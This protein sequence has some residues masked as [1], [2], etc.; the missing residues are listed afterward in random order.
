MT[1][2]TF[3]AVYADYECSIEVEMDYHVLEARYVE[4]HVIW[5]RFR[6]GTASE[7]DLAP[8]LRGPIFKPLHDLAFF[9]TFSV[10]PEF[11][12]LVWPNGADIANKVNW[13]PQ[14]LRWLL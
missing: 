10:H 11:H 7:I 13:Q 9:Q 1:L 3:H 12:T 6:D 5:L 8:A 14:G 4:Q 2:R